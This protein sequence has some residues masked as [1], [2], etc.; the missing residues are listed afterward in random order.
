MKVLITIS[1]FCLTMIIDVFSQ[2]TKGDQAYIKNVLKPLVNGNLDY[3]NLLAVDSLRII[4]EKVESKSYK[5]SISLEIDDNSEVNYLFMQFK[6]LFNVN[7]AADQKLK[8]VNEL[9]NI[10]E[11]DKV[12]EFANF[13]HKLK[14]N[15]D[16][17]LVFNLLEEF[18]S[19]TGMFSSKKDEKVP[20]LEATFFGL[21]IY[22]ILVK[23]SKEN[24]ELKNKLEKY[25]NNLKNLLNGPLNSLQYLTNNMA[26]FTD[27]NSDNF[28]LNRLAVETFTELM[29][30][31]LDENQKLQEMIFNIRNYFLKFK[32][33]ITSLEKIHSILKVLEL[34]NY[35]PIVKFTKNSIFI[36]EDQNIPFSI[37]DSFGN[38]SKHFNVHF[39]YNRLN[40]E[41]SSNSKISSEDIDDLP[42]ENS[43]SEGKFFE[44][45]TNGEASGIINFSDINEFGDY[46]Y[47][48]EMKIEDVNNGKKYV[49]SEILSI[50]ASPKIKINYISVSVLDSD[51]SGSKSENKIEFPKRSFKS[52]KGNQNS[53]LKIKLKVSRFSL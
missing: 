38:E 23:N 20:S 16:W 17:G 50:R 6:E 22:Y 7:I 15:C 39:R 41:N 9:Q 40:T 49:F 18:K 47:N 2:L 52:F 25:T 29:E 53:V 12:Y 21:R 4:G 28:R 27:L 46:K 14:L 45:H 13:H 1:I 35:K 36:D 8:F 3:E 11:I 19:D 51:N 37:V 43:S 48:V 42:D 26:I 24:S 31:N 34:T 44:K 32:S 10:S 33:G 30:L 5:K